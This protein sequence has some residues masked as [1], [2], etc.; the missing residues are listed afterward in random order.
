MSDDLSKLFNQA[1]NYKNAH[2]NMSPIELFYGFNSW[3]RIQALNLYNR[4]F[5]LKK[6]L[7]IFGFSFDETE[8]VQ[9]ED[10]IGDN[11]ITEEKWEEIKFSINQS[12]TDKGLKNSN[13][14]KGDND[15][16]GDDGLSP[17][18]VPVN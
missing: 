3:D 2:P 9:L 7:G 12:L 10:M 5:A 1:N 14:D 16:S 13:N 4:A 6:L 15:D 11:N 17:S 8:S 18:T